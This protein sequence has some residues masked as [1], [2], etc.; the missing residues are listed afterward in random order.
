[1]RIVFFLLVGFFALAYAN[2]VETLSEDEWDLP[3]Q[4]GT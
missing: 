4:E 2:D 3:L 1:M